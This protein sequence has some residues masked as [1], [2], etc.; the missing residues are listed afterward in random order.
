MIYGPAVLISV[1]PPGAVPLLLPPDRVSFSRDA[2][3]T[4]SSLKASRRKR[5]LRGPSVDRADSV[6]IS[7]SDVVIR[8]QETKPLCDQLLNWME[9]SGG[10]LGDMLVAPAASKITGGAVN[11]GNQLPSVTFQWGPPELG[12]FYQVRLIS[13]QIQFVRFNRHGAAIR[14][15]ASITMQTIPSLLGSLPTNPTSGG[16]A[17]R[18]SHTMTEGEDLQA[19]ARQ[20]YGNPSAWRGVAE[21][22]GIEDPLRVRPGRQLYLPNPDELPRRTP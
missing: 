16:L 17:G 11:L 8:G 1:A 6:K 3:L 15:K 4:E 14:A 21:A 13:C 5:A 9:P 2:R 7:L 19:V 10:A 12:F 22:N 20:Q 18:A